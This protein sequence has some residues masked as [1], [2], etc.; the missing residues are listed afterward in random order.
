M[1]AQEE[2]YEKNEASQGST[3]SEDDGESEEEAVPEH[4]MQYEENRKNA[5]IE[6]EWTPDVEEIK[7]EGTLGNAPAADDI[8]DDFSN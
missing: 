7:K 8:S 5:E 4:P 3:A 2:E 6:E 1:M